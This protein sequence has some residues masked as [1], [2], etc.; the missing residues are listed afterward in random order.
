MISPA[1]PAFSS[2][3]RVKGS[4]EGEERTE[5]LLLTLPSFAVAPTLRD[6]NMNKVSP[7]Q[8]TPALQ[9][10]YDWIN[11]TGYN[12]QSLFGPHTRECAKQNF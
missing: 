2:G 8:N 12:K 4:G 7:N 11:I 10:I 5:N 9:A 3:A 1:V 6:T